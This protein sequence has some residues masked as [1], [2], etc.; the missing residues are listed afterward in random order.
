MRVV[1]IG[2]SAERLVA[3]EGDRSVVSEL[4]LVVAGSALEAAGLERWA[5]SYKGTYYS[6]SD[7]YR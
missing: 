2:N 4:V 3:G 1:R 5:W 6:L 7:Q